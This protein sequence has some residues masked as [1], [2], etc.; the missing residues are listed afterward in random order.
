MELLRSAT[1]FKKKDI[2]LVLSAFVKVISENVLENGNDVRLAG[3]GTFRQ[4]VTAGRT[5]RNPKTGLP[6]FI[7][8]GKSVTFSAA[9]N[10]RRKNGELQKN[11][12]D[13]DTA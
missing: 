8:G 3:L 13:E 4:K 7:F 9:T 2:E 6:I 11:T 12:S 10:M 1:D 5:G